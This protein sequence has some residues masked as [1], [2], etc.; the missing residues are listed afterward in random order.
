MF[1]FRYDY[2]KVKDLFVN[3]KIFLPFL[4]E[5]RFCVVFFLPVLTFGYVFLLIN[6][7]SKTDRC[8][9]M[10]FCAFLRAIDEKSMGCLCMDDEKCLPL[11]PI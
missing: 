10:S 8:D 3:N 5:G 1:R 2:D 6:D 4:R 11:Q 7:K 9:L